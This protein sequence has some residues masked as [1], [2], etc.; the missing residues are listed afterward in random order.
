MSL[1]LYNK[2]NNIIKHQS[3]I[4]SDTKTLIFDYLIE[5]IF[6]AR[7]QKPRQVQTH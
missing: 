7:Q 4:R 6:R 2:K 1:N 3:V 5:K